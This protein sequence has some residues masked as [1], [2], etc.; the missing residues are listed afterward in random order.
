MRPRV[1][2]LYAPGTNCQ[3]ETATAFRHAGADAA[4][5]PLAELLTGT[6]RLQDADIVC[7]PGGFAFGDHT[8]AGNVAAW[9]LR[10][11]LADQLAACRERPLMAICNGF[12]IAARAGLFGDISLTVNENGTF[13]D[14]ASQRHI[15]TD[16]SSSPWLNN[17]LGA[18]L[19]FPCAHGEGR[20]LYSGRGDWQPA[21]FYPDAENPDG[22]IEN[23]AGITSANGLALGIMDHPERAFRD[24]NVLRL[25]ENAVL[26][27][28]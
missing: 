22:S 1:N 21:L 2:I 3:R 10:V 20:F 27:V 9:F 28:R 19:C 13:Y 24:P 25:F 12:Q 16:S 4:I 8:G 18:S 17:L 11:R 15:V 6:K 14:E 7:F 23:I 26:A 5:V